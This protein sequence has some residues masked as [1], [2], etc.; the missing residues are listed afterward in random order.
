MKINY[1]AGGGGNHVR[2][3][4]YPDKIFPNLEDYSSKLNY[5]QD[6][7]YN[8][9]R[10]WD[11]WLIYEWQWHRTLNETMVVE[12]AILPDDY[13]L[14]QK[15]IWLYYDDLEKVVKRY[16]HI[17]LGGNS[18]SPRVFKKES[19]KWNIDNLYA[20]HESVINKDK[21][22]YLKADF[23]FDKNLDYNAYKQIIDFFELNDHYEDACRIQ[24]MY[25]N[26]R[27]NAAHEFA[28]FFTSKEFND[29]V[30]LMK[31]EK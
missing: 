17:N 28:E 11:N 6:N 7:V 10:S 4:L 2:W 14:H 3:L 31:N 25:Y 15:N 24:E 12:H 8:I 29:Y 23:I 5:I 18:L 13:K 21:L 19:K 16:F 1:P 22:L 30:D 20:K 9:K 27:I 26:C